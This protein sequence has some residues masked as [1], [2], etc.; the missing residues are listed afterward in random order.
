MANPIYIEQRE[1]AGDFGVR[2]STK[3]WNNTVSYD[4]LLV[5]SYIELANFKLP[6]LVTPHIKQRKANEVQKLVLKVW[7]T[8]E[9]FNG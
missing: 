5:L 7:E 3:V 6:S 9:K 8:T 2:V 4:S 1:S